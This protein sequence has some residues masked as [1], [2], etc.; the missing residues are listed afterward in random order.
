MENIY[1]DGTLTIDGTTGILRVCANPSMNTGSGDYMSY[2]IKA[3]ED[4]NFIGGTVELYT[5]PVY[6]KTVDAGSKVTQ[7]ASMS[8]NINMNGGTVQFV[9]DKA[10][11][12][13]I[14]MNK[15]PRLAEGYTQPDVSTLVP[16][17]S[18]GWTQTD[19]SGGNKNAASNQ[20]AN[21]Q[22][23]CGS[24]IAAKHGNHYAKRDGCG[25]HYHDLARV[26]HS[27][28]NCSCF[29]CIYDVSHKY[30]S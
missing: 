20:C 30:P 23:R 21:T 9:A 28:I 19:P 24:I 7:V 14:K 15:T 29:F 4:I 25:S 27:V 22:N 10:P 17:G 18:I 13:I 26:L 8:G 11:T 12:Y 5:K 1:V 3:E 16:N 6:L 2:G